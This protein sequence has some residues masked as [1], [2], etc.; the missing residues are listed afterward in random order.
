MI[1]TALAGTV[2]LWKN[3]ALQNC[4]CSYLYPK[5]I[6]VCLLPFWKVLQYQ[7]V[8]LT[9]VPF[10]L[11]LPYI[12]MC[13]RFCVHPLRVVEKEMATHSSTLAWRVPWM[14]EPGSLQS[15]GLQRVGHN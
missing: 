9:Q 7:Q 14:G 10:R 12:L 11:L 4:R 13:V 6:S 3:E 15:M 5:M 1:Q 2:S 8:G